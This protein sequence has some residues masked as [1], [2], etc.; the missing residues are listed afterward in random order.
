MLRC[1]REIREYYGHYNADQWHAYLTCTVYGNPIGFLA[2]E[3][4][5]V[6]YPDNYSRGMYELDRARNLS[7]FH[8]YPR[9]SN[10]WSGQL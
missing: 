6:D 10:K 9:K 1:T 3:V 4:Y 5:M 8:S 2:R 7:I